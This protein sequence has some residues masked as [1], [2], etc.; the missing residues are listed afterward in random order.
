MR[1]RT[2]VL[3]GASL[4]VAAAALWVGLPRGAPLYAAWR[5]ARPQE[6]PGTLGVVLEP[7]PPG[8]DPS[9][10][11]RQA[12]RAVVRT[13]PPGGVM[14]T[15]A[16]VSSPYSRSAD[17]VPA[18]VVIGR[19]VCDASSK[20]D[21]VSA[22][23][24]DPGAQGLPCTNHNLLMAVVDARTRKVLAVYRG[25]DPTGAWEPAAGTD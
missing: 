2:W 21:V 11:P 16:L 1:R 18:W 13:K 12:Y 14:E 24:S 17:G 10:T 9:V 22:G 6:V 19:G 5:Q 20:G 15:L 7:M 23:R 3:A 25:Y 4:V 8:L